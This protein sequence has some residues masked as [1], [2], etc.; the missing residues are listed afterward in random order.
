MYNSYDSLTTTSG[1][2]DFA[3]TFGSLAAGAIIL[4]VI[5]GIFALAIAV[6]MI[7]AK[8]K[9]YKKAGQEWWKVFIPLYSTW[10]E[11]KITGLAWW[12]CPISVVLAALVGVKE[13]SYV[14]A[15]AV[16]LVEFNYN[17][18]LAKKFGKTNGFAVLCTLLPIIGI[19][20]LAFGS[21]KYDAKAETDKNGIFAVEKDLV[22]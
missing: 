15:F 9:M 20:M 8:C 3:T 4:F 11:T 1:S 2:T 6:F 17:F 22:K 21:A 16:L 12:W 19:P 10:T 13:V 18:N 5:L 7:I 14:V